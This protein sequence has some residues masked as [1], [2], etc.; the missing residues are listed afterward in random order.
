LRCF[1]RDGKAVA[2][3]GQHSVLTGSYYPNIIPTGDAK[4]CPVCFSAA[5]P[6]AGPRN[7]RT[8]NKERFS[9]I[10][11]SRGRSSIHATAERTPAADQA[12]CL[13]HTAI[14][15]KSGSDRKYSPIGH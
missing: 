2:M 10:G 15:V 11:R 6:C 4:R 14:M 1:R 3:M 7:H 13:P 12:Q 9:M 8:E 5:V